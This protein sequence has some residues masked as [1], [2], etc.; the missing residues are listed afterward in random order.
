L[1]SEAVDPSKISLIKLGIDTKIFF[2]KKIINKRSNTNILYIGRLTKEKGILMLLNTFVALHQKIPTCYLRIVG[3]GPLKKRIENIIIK[4]NLTNNVKITTTPYNQIHQHYKWADIFVLPSQNTPT[5]EEQ[6][7][8]V[9]I[10]ALSSGLPIITTDSGAI[11]EVVGT[12]GIIVK[13]NSES[14]LS[15]ALVGLVP[16]KVLQKKLAEKAR[17]RAIKYYNSSYCSEKILKLYEKLYISSN[18]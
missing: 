9:L 1:I 10:E 13:N 12:S 5:W 11:A 6:Y 8:M 15:K 2:P 7:G 3:N 14:E 4:N 17:K 18:N 16:N